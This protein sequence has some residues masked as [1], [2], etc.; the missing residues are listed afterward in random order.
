MP[1]EEA[2]LTGMD[3]K[4]TESRVVTIRPSG[5]THSVSVGSV[6]LHGLPKQL[7]LLVLLG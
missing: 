3:R 2:V 4:M 1:W 5:L 7:H 6:G